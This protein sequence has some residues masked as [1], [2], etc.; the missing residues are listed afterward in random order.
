[1]CNPA[2]TGVA[3]YIGGG[4]SPC[5]KTGTHFVTLLGHPAKM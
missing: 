4:G 3:C 5:G 1:M 2:G